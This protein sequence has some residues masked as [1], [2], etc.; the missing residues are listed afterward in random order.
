VGANVVNQMLKDQPTFASQAKSYTQI[1]SAFGAI[2]GTLLAAL[3]ADW[4]SRRA[5]YVAMCVS[6]FGSVLLLYQGVSGYGP[7]LLGAMFIAGFCT[8][9][10]YGW[11]PLYLPELF[12]TSVRATGQGFGFNFGRILA[13]VAA[14]QT[15]NLMG[16]FSG[17]Y[18]QACSVMSA[19][20]LVGLC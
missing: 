14:L 2:C 5:T 20:Y 16:L 1:A 17:G 9:S 19:V 6:S 13:A 4:T 11:L 15:G 18:P 7:A 3:A 12:R 10:F 8:A